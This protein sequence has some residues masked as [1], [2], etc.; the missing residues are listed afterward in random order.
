MAA[1]KIH[2][3]RGAGPYKRALRQLA[4]FLTDEEAV[5]FTALAPIDILKAVARI[6]LAKLPE[7]F[8]WACVA[9]G[10]FAVKDAGCS[11]FGADHKRGQA[12][13]GVLRFAA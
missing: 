13:G 7:F 6:I 8:A 3:G 2:A 9:L 5:G 4:F 11:A 1:G 12:G 10:V